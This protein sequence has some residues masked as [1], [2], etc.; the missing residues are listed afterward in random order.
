MDLILRLGKWGEPFHSFE[1]EEDVPP[2]WFW[3]GLALKPEQVQ[4][5]K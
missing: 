3:K 4:V 5:L 1:E 2:W